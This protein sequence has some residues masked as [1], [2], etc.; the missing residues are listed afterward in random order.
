MNKPNFGKI[1]NAC[2]R[3]EL[4]LWFRLDRY[5]PHVAYLCALG[6]LSIWVSYKIEMTMI[7]VEENKEKLETIIVH[8][9]QKT[10]E[11][12]GMDC[13]STVEMMLQKMESDVKAP[14][15]PAMIIRNR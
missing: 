14:Q 8:H 6:F 2:L 5:L 10:C 1:L 13:R 11:A 4:L 9:A 7:K 3:G 15:K 12:A